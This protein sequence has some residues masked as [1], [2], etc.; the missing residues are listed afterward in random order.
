MAAISAVR[1]FG[2]YRLRGDSERIR[3][4]VRTADDNDHHN[5]KACAI[6]FLILQMIAE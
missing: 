3:R 2:H 5:H 6:F 4:T 1:G